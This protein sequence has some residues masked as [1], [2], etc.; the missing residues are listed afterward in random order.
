MSEFYHI[1]LA[2]AAID[3]YDW[4]ARQVTQDCFIICA[5]SGLR[6]AEAIGVKP[7]IITGDFDSVDPDLLDSYRGKS[8]IV[9]NPDQNSTDLMKAL[10]QLPDDSPQVK[11]F[12]AVGQRADHDFATYLTLLAHDESDR[13]VLH[14]PQDQ[15][16]VIK[17]PCTFSGDKG[18]IIG[19][20]P[21]AEISN[22]RVT[23]LKYDP[24]IL[25]G[26]YHFGW[27]GACNEMTAKTANVTFDSGAVLLTHSYKKIVP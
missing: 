26:P 9:F 12:G 24:S 5:D 2:G 6:H 19:L 1:I 23:G 21:L 15:R 11:I 20:F 4:L 14:T 16:R 7:D 17:A 3:D 8:R 22:L 18:D 27:N 13:L 10:D 25:G